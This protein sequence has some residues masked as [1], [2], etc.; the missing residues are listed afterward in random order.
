MDFLENLPPLLQTFWYV[1]IPTSLI[2]ILQS[3]MTFVGTDASDGVNADFDGDF[4]GAETPFQLFS[5]RNLINFLLGFSWSGISFFGLIKNSLIL[6]STSV[7]VGVAFV[8]VFFVIIRQIQKL[9][10]DNTFD[11]QKLINKT[12]EVYLSIPA[13]KSGKGKIQISI[14]GAFH[15]LDAIT[16]HDTLPTGSFIKV[17]KAIDSDLVIVEKI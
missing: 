1:A 15:E 2:F 17:V 7:L 3:I 9:A 16:E 6:I 11:I 5:L 13:K 4:E 10:E 8:G 12:G 14:N